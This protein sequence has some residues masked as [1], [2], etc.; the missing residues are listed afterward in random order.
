MSA[1]HAKG[2]VRGRELREQALGNADN[3]NVC[4]GHAAA[5]SDGFRLYPLAVDTS[6][7]QFGKGMFPARF[8]GRC[9]LCDQPFDAGAAM[10]YRPSDKALAHPACVRGRK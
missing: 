3:C 5:Y 2:D 7:D 4:A 1:G 10:Q 9:A 6:H 8:P